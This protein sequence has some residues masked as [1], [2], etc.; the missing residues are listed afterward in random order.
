[1]NVVIHLWE[2]LC[3]CAAHKQQSIET[4]KLKLSLKYAILQCRL[5]ASATDTVYLPT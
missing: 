2:G 1:M 5:A 4:T 3:Y